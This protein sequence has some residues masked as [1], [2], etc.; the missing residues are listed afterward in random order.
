MQM[1]KNDTVEKD[2]QTNRHCENLR[3]QKLSILSRNLGNGGGF[4]RTLYSA[5]QSKLQ[6]IL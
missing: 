3:L 2:G 4:D 1:Q 5:S 6:K